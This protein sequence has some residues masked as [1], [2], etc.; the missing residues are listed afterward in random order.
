VLA[1]AISKGSRL[2]LEWRQEKNNQKKTKKNDH[3]DNP[4]TN[5]TLQSKIYHSLDLMPKRQMP[6]RSPNRTQTIFQKF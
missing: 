4:Q 3:S 1:I 2:Y 6:K 5:S